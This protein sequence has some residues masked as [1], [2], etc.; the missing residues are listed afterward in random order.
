MKGMSTHFTVVQDNGRLS[1]APEEDLVVH[2]EGN[3][4]KI[5]SEISAG[6]KTILVE[7]KD[8][9][10]HELFVVRLKKGK[11]E[12]DFLRWMGEKIQTKGELLREAR[13]KF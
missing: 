1:K 11:T 10:P 9:R 5:P 4:F 6:K 7:N 13:G 3:S 8:E 2:M 12:E